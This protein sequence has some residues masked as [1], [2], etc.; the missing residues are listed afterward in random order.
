[1]M[2]I[3]FLSVT[4]YYAFTDLISIYK[5]KQWKTFFIYLIVF[6]LI[7]MTAILA[8][9]N[10]IKPSPSAAVKKIIYSIFGLQ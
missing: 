5:G 4:A 1:M 7:I 3:L 2:L 6:V 9:A 10:V 8:E